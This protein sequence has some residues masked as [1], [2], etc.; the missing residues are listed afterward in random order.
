MTDSRATVPVCPCTARAMKAAQAAKPLWDY[1]I[2]RRE[3]AELIA[4]LEKHGYVS[5]DAERRMKQ[6]W[7]LHS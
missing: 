6:L 2:T 5:A 1:T 7:A 4:T 3:T